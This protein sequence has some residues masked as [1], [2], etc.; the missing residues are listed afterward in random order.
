[1]PVLNVKMLIHWNTPFW[2]APLALSSIKKYYLGS[3]HWKIQINLSKD[4]N[5][6]Y[7]CGVR[8]EIRFPPMTVS[9]NHINL[10]LRF[11]HKNLPT[12]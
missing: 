1:M 7:S 8:L 9:F 6:I 10:A 4:F 2:N 11:W 12:S 3:M 5:L